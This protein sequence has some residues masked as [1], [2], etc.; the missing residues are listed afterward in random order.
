MSRQ[1]TNKQKSYALVAPMVVLPQGIH[2]AN[3]DGRRQIRHGLREVPQGVA[4]RVQATSAESQFQPH[5]RC[6]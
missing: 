3:P 4:I 6:F 1:V 5:L 2:P